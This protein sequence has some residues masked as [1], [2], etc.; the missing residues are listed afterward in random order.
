VFVC[1]ELT[2]QRP[3]G[4]KGETMDTK[5]ENPLD[6]M[7]HCPDCGHDFKTGN[8]SKHGGCPKCNSQAWQTKT[9]PQPAPDSPLEIVI[10]WA[11]NHACAAD[12]TARARYTEIVTALRADVEADKAK[13]DRARAYARHFCHYAGQGI[14]CATCTGRECAY[15]YMMTGETMSAE[16]RAARQVKP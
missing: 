5:T 15:H 6:R 14:D 3:E 12:N 1:S 13:M 8:Q 7:Q 11:S 4:R 2:D 16:L 10:G 9:E